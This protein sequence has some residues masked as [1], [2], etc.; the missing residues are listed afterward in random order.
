VLPAHGPA[1]CVKIIRRE[2]GSINQLTAELMDLSRGKVIEK[3]S[4]VL[5][6][7]GSHL[8][9]VGTVAYT[10]DLTTAV[11][12]IRS[13]LG[14]DI[15]VA[16]LPPMFLGGCNSEEL[17]RSCAEVAVWADA[18]FTEED[19]YMQESCRKAAQMLEAGPGDE[20]QQ[21]YRIKMRLPASTTPT[22]GKQTWDLGG[23]RLRKGM[24]P[25]TPDKESEIILSLVN[26]VRAKLAI[27]ID[28][29]PAFDR[30]TPEITDV[31][32]PARSNKVY[33]AVG[34]QHA[35]NLTEA[36]HR[37][38]D[39]V[40]AVIIP[41]WK[42]TAVGVCILEERMKEAII[43]RKPDVIL[44]HCLD[45]N[46]FFGL[47][48][49]GSTVAAKKGDDGVEH[50]EG[51]LV[52]GKKDS[53]ELVFRRME[54][55]W[56]ATKGFATLVLV[57][58]VRY[59]AKACCE[60]AQHVTN[61]LEPDFA[62]HQKR[63]LMELSLGLKS[64][65]HNTGRS[66]CQVMDPN[67]DLNQVEARHVWGDDPIYPLPIGYDK[68]AVGVQTVEERSVQRRQNEAAKLAKRPRMEQGERAAG[69]SVPVGGQ[70]RMGQP[71]A[72][73]RYQRVSEA[74][75]AARAIRGVASGSR[76]GRGSGNTGNGGRREF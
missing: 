70:E 63:D 72:D 45:D 33:L 26:E 43:K 22:A 68:M 50:I 59:V 16:P 54:P 37:K 47:M 30:K 75:A 5:I 18:V 40:D 12:A 39:V 71:E 48:E 44:L 64:Y 10:E 67:V 53:Q 29:A 20:A 49:D 55:L 14:Q 52:V 60:E 4:L 46:M 76:G 9:R 23:F 2:F 11:A 21:D 13:V 57:P 42:A 1:M 6:F 74:N 61:R 24:K 8:A 25:A 27:N 56:E 51:R 28:A 32:V 65:L 3:E 34:G 36:M 58:T 19:G 66:L 7:S 35:L 38:G 73:I 17:I 62:A 31:R 69:E 41:G 15:K